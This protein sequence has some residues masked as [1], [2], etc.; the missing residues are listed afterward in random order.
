MV[1][2]AAYQVRYFIGSLPCVARVIDCGD[3]GGHRHVEGSGEADEGFQA[4]GDLGRF[5]LLDAG[6]V[7]VGQFRQLLLGE[8]A[9]WAKAAEMRGQLMLLGYFGGLARIAPAL[10]GENG[11]EAALT[12]KKVHE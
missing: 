9:F 5:D 4:R 11:Q 6:G 3:E 2:Q 1:W 12:V 8:P 7:K 10:S